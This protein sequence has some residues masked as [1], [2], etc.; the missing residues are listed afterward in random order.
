MK[1]SISTTRRQTLLGW[2]YL[3]VS[4]FVLPSVLNT[5]NGLLAT[6]LTESAL[7]LIFFIVNFV[8]VVCIFHTFLWESLKTAAEKIWKCLGF[9]ALGIAAYYVAMWLMAQVIGAIKADFSNINDT[10]IFDM[11][12]QHTGLLA[13]AT[14]FLV[15]I[16]EETLYRGLLFQTLHRQNRLM[17]YVVSVAVFAAIHIVGYVGVSDSL[18]LALCFLQY[19]P[20]GI[21]L[22]LAYEETDT[23]ITPILIHIFINLIGISAQR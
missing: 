14:V 2:A 13:F 17:G 12:G 1:L 18:T 16:T 9:A 19:L 4:I 3:L 11:M 22:A 21:I 15:P 8:A 6:P 20:A 10:A 7:N 5:V 23:I